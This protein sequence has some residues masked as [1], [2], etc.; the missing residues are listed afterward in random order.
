MK[1]QSR[2][3]LESSDTLYKGRKM[4]FNAFKSRIF[5]LPPVKYARRS[6]MLVSRPSVSVY[7]GSGF[8]S[9]TF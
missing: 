8:W 5:W 1:K 9:Y 2:D 6:G 4:V 3:T 7:V